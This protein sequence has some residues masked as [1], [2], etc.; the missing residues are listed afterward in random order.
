MDILSK[1]MGRLPLKHYLHYIL[2]GLFTTIISFGSFWILMTLLDVQPNPANIISVIL[3]V[4]FAYIANKI[5]VFKS[6]CGNFTELASELFRFAVARGLSVLTEIG[7]LF[8]LYSVFN[9]KALTAKIL[10]SVFV[11]IL[12]YLFFKFYIFKKPISSDICPQQDDA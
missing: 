3:A 7:G 5:A 6:R 12:N 11:L 8:L 1:N 10:I 4:L 9:F 2:I